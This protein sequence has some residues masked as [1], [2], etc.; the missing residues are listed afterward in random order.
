MA[1]K[2]LRKI[3]RRALVSGVLSLPAFSVRAQ[4]RTLKRFAI[5]SPTEPVA[6]MI[7]DGPN[8]YYR[9]LF[10][11]LRSLG[12]V[13]GK[14]LIVERYSRENAAGGLETMIA[15]VV[16]SKPDVIY[17]IG[18]G[19]RLKAATTTIPVVAMTYDPV[20]LGLAKTLARPGGN[21]TGVS[22]DTGPGLY[23]KRIELLRE[24]VP[25]MTRFGFLTSRLVWD[26][27]QGPVVRAA[28]D[29]ARSA[30][31]P[32]LVDLPAT[33]DQYRQAVRAARADG[34]GAI[35]IGDSPET[36]QYR[37]DIVRVVAEAGLPAMYT[38]PE[39]VEVGGLLAYSFDLKELNQQAARNIDAIL[40]GANPGEIPFYQL[41]RLILSI[42]LGTAKTLGIVFPASILARADQVIE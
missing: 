19:V 1:F 26:L 14:T 9:V 16:R 40:R 20:A 13:E 21:F 10:Q 34:V 30:V 27:F 23:G 41:T 5:F 38:F 25:G 18:G 28:T 36:L 29:A 8:P 39:S 42:N 11:A 7:E 15:E 31:S 33:V 37:S 22:V 12:H 3:R 4:N 32:F 17:A 24:V 2:E 6:I 35:I